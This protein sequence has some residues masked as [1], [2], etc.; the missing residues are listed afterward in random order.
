MK[1]ADDGRYKVYIYA[2]DHNPPHCHVIC[3]DGEEQ[4]ITIPDLKV[5]IG[6]DLNRQVKNLLIENLEK[7]IIIWDEYTNK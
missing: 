4:L 3:S 5:L 2:N 1:I 7:M 6:A